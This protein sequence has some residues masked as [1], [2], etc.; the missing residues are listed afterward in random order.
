[1]LKGNN[2]LEDWQFNPLIKHNAA[3][4]MITQRQTLNDLEGI[5]HLWGNPP[6]A[7]AG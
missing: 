5:M 6:L 7:V 3:P 4:G 2:L 1:V